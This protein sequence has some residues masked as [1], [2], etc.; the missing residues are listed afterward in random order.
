MYRRSTDNGAS[1][2]DAR[3][4]TS[5]YWWL[6]PTYIAASG[7]GV[8]IAMTYHEADGDPNKRPTLMTLNSGNGGT[9]FTANVVAIGENFDKPATLAIPVVD[10]KRLGNRVFLLYQRQFENWNDIWRSFAL[11]CA[12]SL[13][14]GATFKSNQMTTP[15]AST[16]YLTWTIQDA[17]YSPNLAVD[18]NHVYVVW[19]QTD[20]AE[21][22]YYNKDDSLYLRRSADQG[23]TFAEPQLLAQ[24]KTDGIGIMQK[25]QETVAAQGGYVYVVFMTTD[26]IVYLRRFADNGVGFSPLQNIGSGAWWPNMVVD[27][28]NGANIHVFWAYIYRYS[29]DGG[30]SFT[31]PVALMPWTGSQYF[32]GTQMALEPGDT[33]HFA[34]SLQYYTQAY[35]F[36]DMDI[37][38]RRYGPAPAPSGRGRR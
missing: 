35:G 30:A 33:K 17:S 1:F 15:A 37:F 36:G 22:A 7:G 23:Q 6:T 9:T 12:A 16:K 14:G 24:N 3:A 11:N 26:G 8:S 28:A 32:G 4:L 10:L 13:D 27:P 5:Q 25:G 34:A 31:P 19:T 2:E 21:G 38:Y 29:A 18:G 20:T